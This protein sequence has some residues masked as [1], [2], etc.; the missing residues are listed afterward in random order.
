MDSP[1]GH[2]GWVNWLWT[3]SIISC[4]VS[5]AIKLFTS[6]FASHTTIIIPSVTKP[7][8]TNTLISHIPHA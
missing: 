8:T 2:C 4:M 3:L 6:S 7:L 1:Y 5:E